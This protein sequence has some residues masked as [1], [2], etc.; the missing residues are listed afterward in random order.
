M[1]KHT[2]ITLAASALLIATPSVLNLYANNKEQAQDQETISDRVQNEIKTSVEV[3]TVVEKSEIEKVETQEM[4][5]TILPVESASIQE[6][7]PTEIKPVPVAPKPAEATPVPVPVTPKPA[8]ATPVPVPV[9]VTLTPITATTPIQPVEQ[10]LTTEPAVAV[11]Q[12]STTPEA[13][14][15]LEVLRLTN[16]E[17]QKAGLKTLTYLSTLD[18]GA[19]IRSIEIITHF[20]HTRPDGSRFFTVFGPNFQYRN[21]GENLAT[22]FRTPEQVVNAWMNSDSHRANILNERFEQLSVAVT[23]G[24]DGKFRWVQ[25]F[26]RAR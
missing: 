9:S 11:V 7:K 10:P 26:F 17:R 25:I 21:I 8:E 23:R 20:S 19:K 12:V 3:M 6:T 16:I 15:E 24:D 22:G 14:W 2:F 4:T 5:P 1:L 13:T 18:E